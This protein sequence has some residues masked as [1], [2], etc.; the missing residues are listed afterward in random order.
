MGVGDERHA[1][2]AVPPDVARYPLCRRLAGPWTGAENSP[3]P[4]FDLRTVQPVASRC[5]C[6]LDHSGRASRV[7]GA[8]NVCCKMQVVCG[9]PFYSVCRELCTF[10]VHFCSDV[11]FVF[12]SIHFISRY[13][14]YKRAYS[15]SSQVF[16]SF[17]FSFISFA[18]LPCFLHACS[19]V[20]C[21]AYSLFSPR[22]CGTLRFSFEVFPITQC[23]RLCNDA[24]NILI[25]T[26]QLHTSNKNKF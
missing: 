13:C 5:S 24:V 3:P 8:M 17:P 14:S 22:L 19:R 15:N 7:G 18:F 20:L 10:S 11:L 1:P 2:T 26:S 12:P 4:E 9:V 23:R 6:R 21:Q 16:F 25:E